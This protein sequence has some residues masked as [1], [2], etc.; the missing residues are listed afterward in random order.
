MFVEIGLRAVVVHYDWKLGTNMK[1]EWD[2]ERGVILKPGASVEVFR[3]AVG[4]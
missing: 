4:V 3:K 2:M 1:E